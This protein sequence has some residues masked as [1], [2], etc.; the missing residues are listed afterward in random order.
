MVVLVSRRSGGADYPA[1][2]LVFCSGLLVGE[3]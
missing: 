2:A 3:P 1:A